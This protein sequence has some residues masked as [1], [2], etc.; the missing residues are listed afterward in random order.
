MAGVATL[1]LYRP[2]FTGASDA[3]SLNLLPKKHN[4][5]HLADILG[6]SKN[7]HRVA[8]YSYSDH[9]YSWR[10]SWANSI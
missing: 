6:Q 3:P 5:S 4:Q 10:N 1:K 9:K 8:I 7:S 2:R